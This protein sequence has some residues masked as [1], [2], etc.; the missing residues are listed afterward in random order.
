MKQI[1][2]G[3]FLFWACQRLGRRFWAWWRASTDLPPELVRRSQ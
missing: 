1:L 3:A 2:L